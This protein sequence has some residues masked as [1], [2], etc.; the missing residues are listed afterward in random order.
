MLED[1]FVIGQRVRFNYEGKG[2]WKGA[3]VRGT[4]TVVGIEA[5]SR[6]PYIVMPEGEVEHSGKILGTVAGLHF[7]ADELEMVV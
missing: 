2:F 1:S 3:Y 5:N 4:G 6:W 7:A